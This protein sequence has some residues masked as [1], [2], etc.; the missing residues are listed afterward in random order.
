MIG[1]ALIGQN[2]TSPRYFHGRPSATTPPYNAGA[3]GASNLGPTSK[4]LATRVRAEADSSMP[5]IRPRPSRS[6]W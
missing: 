2:F 4:A 3:S 6:I 1:S 5:K